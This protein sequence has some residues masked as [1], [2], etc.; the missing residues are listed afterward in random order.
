[1]HRARAVGR[2]DLD[3]AEWAELARTL[4]Q[5]GGARRLG[6]VGEIYR[7]DMGRYGE[8]WGALALAG[9]AGRL[10]RDRVG[11]GVGVGVGL[12]G[13]ELGLGLE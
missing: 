3:P 1:M 13:L 11:V 5:A 8:I 2:V 9:G 10:D 4:A 6:D 7:G 12:V